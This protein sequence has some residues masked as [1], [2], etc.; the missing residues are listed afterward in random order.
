MR[1]MK[2]FV[3]DKK[4]ET[5]VETLSAILIFTLASIILY[6]M[7]TSAAGVNKKAREQDVI[8]GNQLSVAEHADAPMGTGTV[9]IS[10]PAA[11]EGGIPVQVAEFN[12]SI[13]RNGDEDSLYSYFKA[14]PTA[15]AEGG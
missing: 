11:A 6:T 1:V 2:K 4:G 8:I 3:N 12:V 9:T 10:I 13:Y 15:P 14:E 7:V 5:L